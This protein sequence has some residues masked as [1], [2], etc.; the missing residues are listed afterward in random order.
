MST[1]QSILSILEK[2]ESTQ[3]YVQMSV[4]M[5]P[6]TKP[7]IVLFGLRLINAVLP[8]PI[9]HMYADVSLTATMKG[10][11]IAHTLPSSI[12]YAI[13]LLANTTTIALITL[14]PRQ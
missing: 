8:I 11:K 14:N 12:M 10:T 4:R 1:G 7:S 9:P 3:M 2:R 5:A 6:P 13:Q